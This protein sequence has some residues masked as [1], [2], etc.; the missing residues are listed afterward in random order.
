MSQ[1][2]RLR[3]RFVDQ[4]DNPGCFDS[5]RQ[6]FLGKLLFLNLAHERNPGEMLSQTVVQVLSYAALFFS[7]DLKNRFFQT[8]ALGDI[9]SRRNN[10]G[11]GSVFSGQNCA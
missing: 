11:R 4:A 3:D 7:A 6:T 9:D 5:L 2:S 10:I 8:L 1:F